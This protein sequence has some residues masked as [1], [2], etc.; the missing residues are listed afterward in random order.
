MFLV[1]PAP[2]AGRALVGCGEAGP[3]SWSSAEPEISR[4]NPR[5]PLHARSVRS[6]AP[7]PGACVGRR[8]PAGA[9]PG[10]PELSALTKARSFLL[11]KRPLIP[12]G[13]C[14]VSQVPTER[15][16]AGEPV[17][18]W[19]LRKG[20]R[21]GL[22]TQGWGRHHSLRRRVRAAWPVR[23][24]PG[25]PTPLPDPREERSRRRRRRSGVRVRAACR[26]EGAPCDPRAPQAR[27]AR[28]TAVS[29]RDLEAS[30]SL[31]HVGR[32]D[33]TRGHP[34]GFSA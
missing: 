7:P 24:L 33:P 8:R 16:L 15:F 6:S 30:P 20:G 25:S 32:G 14:L 34:R 3:R 2:G 31:C 1:A 28:G 21:A 5:K 17:F 9:R 18:L 27:S 23:R 4:S 19:L 11:A 29:F 26:P 22:L 12:A 13:F 10:A